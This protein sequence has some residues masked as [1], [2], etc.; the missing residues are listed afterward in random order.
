MVGE[1]INEPGTPLYSLTYSQLENGAMYEVEK[2]KSIYLKLQQ[3]ITQVKGDQIGWF[4]DNKHDFSHLKFR[5]LNKYSVVQ[6][7]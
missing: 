6:L 4:W 1:L 3:G 5:R 2:S 7:T